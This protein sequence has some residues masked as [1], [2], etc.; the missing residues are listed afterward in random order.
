MFGLFKKKSPKPK[1]DEIGIII[2]ALENFIPR[3]EK[4]EW[5]KNSEWHWDDHMSIQFDDKR[6]E[7][8]RQLC[9]QVSDAFPGEG[10]ICYSPEGLDLL[11]TVLKILKKERHL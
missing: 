9:W 2:E 7:A 5:D 4:N 6:A 1:L 11:K 3:F 8:L 10:M